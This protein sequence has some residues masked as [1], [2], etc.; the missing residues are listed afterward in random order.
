MS[1]RVYGVYPFNT[2]PKFCDWSYTHQFAY[3]TIIMPAILK[4]KRA[5]VESN[6]SL[7]M[8]DELF[9]ELKT[10]Q[11]LIAKIGEAVDVP[12]LIAE[13]EGRKYVSRDTVLAIHDALFT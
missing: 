2:P 10:T 3:K 11:Q 7:P 4:S 5:L 13:Y 8:T 6:S 1:Y 12:V 9:A